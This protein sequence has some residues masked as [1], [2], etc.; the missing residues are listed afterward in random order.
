[1]TT[2]RS[3]RFRRTT[4]SRPAAATTPPPRTKVTSDT[5]EAEQKSEEFWAAWNTCLTKRAQAAGIETE[6]ITEGEAKGEVGPNKDAAGGDGPL[7]KKWRDEII[8]ACGR[9]I[10]APRPR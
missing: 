3:P 4:G 1:M 8:R 10:L 9:E 7:A 2:P 5:P 6:V